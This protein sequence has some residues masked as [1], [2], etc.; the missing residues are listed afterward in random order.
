M[1][2]FYD[3]SDIHSLD[4]RQIF[5]DANI[6]LYIFWPTGSSWEK[7]YSAIF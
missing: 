1:A 2:K 5:F 4:K 6:L 3:S 7:Q